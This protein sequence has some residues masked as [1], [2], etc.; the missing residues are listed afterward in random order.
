MRIK[1]SKSF[2]SRNAT[3]WMCFNKLW[4]AVKIALWQH[5]NCIAL[6]RLQ[7]IRKMQGGKES[8][9]VETWVSWYYM[10]VFSTFFSFVPFF[11]QKTAICML[12]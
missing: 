5:P 6:P 9:R 12:C 3:S 2:A 1:W 8:S 4:R 10:T 11:P 7:F